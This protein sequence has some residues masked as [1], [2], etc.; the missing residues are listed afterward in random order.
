MET[1]RSLH[2]AEHGARSDVA[3]VALG[4][5]FYDGVGAW[6]GYIYGFVLL[7]CLNTIGDDAL[8]DEG[9]DGVVDEEGEGRRRWGSLRSLNGLRG[10]IE[11]DGCERRV[12]ALFPSR[13]DVLY[14][15]VGGCN[16]TDAVNIVSMC[17]DNDLVDAFML[18]EGTDGVFEYCAAGN[19][20]ELFRFGSAHAA[21]AA[22]G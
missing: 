21:S 11:S 12:V 1:L 5:D 4:I 17:Y 14:F 16:L 20:N 15:G 19:L 10:L 6:D 13:H 22:A 18:M 7:Q 8:A 3:D 9:A 2:V